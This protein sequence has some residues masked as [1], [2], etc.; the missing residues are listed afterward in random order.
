TLTPDL[1]RDLNRFREEIS[2]LLKNE[3][4]ARYFYQKGSTQATLET[5]DAVKK[6]KEILAN[7]SD[8]KK[9]LLPK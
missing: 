6:A 9:T 4:I 8:Y 7:S 3:I 5:D 2:L 1:D